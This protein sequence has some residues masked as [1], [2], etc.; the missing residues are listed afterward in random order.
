MSDVTTPS[1]GASPTPNPT[2]AS[3]EARARPT[4]LIGVVSGVAIAGLVALL[5][6]LGLGG[7]GGGSGD[8]DVAGPST[9]PASSTV[10]AAG[11]VLLDG[12]ALGT[13]EVL[14]E[15]VGVPTA[16]A[17]TET[18]GIS[19][20][21]S[22][23]VALPALPMPTTTAPLSDQQVPL[24]QIAGNEPGLYGGTRDVTACDTAQLAEFL[25]SDP[26]KG[27]AWAAVQRIEAS[28]LREFIESLTPLTLTRDTRVTNHGYADGV[29]LPHQSVLQAGHAVLV[30]E[31]GVPR[32]KCSCGN[33]LAPPQPLSSAPTYVG[34]P[35]PEFDPTVIIVIVSVTPVGDEFVVV[36]LGTGELIEVPI[37]GFSGPDPVNE[38]ANETADGPDPDSDQDVDLVNVGNILAVTPG[39][40]AGATFTVD[41]PTLITWVSNY[42]YGPETAPGQVGLT[43]SDGSF[44]GPWQTVG[45]EG[46]G[47][48][49]NAYWNAAPYAVIPAGTYTVWDSDPSTWSSNADTGGVGFTVVRGIIGVLEDADPPTTMPTATPATTPSETNTTPNSPGQP[50]WSP[51]D[52]AG[53]ILD[54]LLLDCGA[55]YGGFTSGGGDTNGW[56]WLVDTP[57]GTADFYVGF[58]DGDPGWFIN[59]DNDVAITL[60]RTCGF[61]EVG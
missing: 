20:E 15:P 42:H 52:A 61:L 25:E 45:A 44:F 3:N 18:V 53:Q 7:N 28:E 31:T 2:P 26:A 11:E 29:A 56:R 21:A 34:T 27:A 46:Q 48:V 40:T 32:A 41:A 16:R 33:P 50:E 12:S 43:A 35:W 19:F 9:G 14:L 4:L 10:V 17:F 55:D 8:D 30:D 5:V 59:A 51:A 39:A 38:T 54:Q 23:T 36:E 49:A 60:A 37:G 6:T 58:I 13:G 24:A 47:G 22:P 57:A 1:D